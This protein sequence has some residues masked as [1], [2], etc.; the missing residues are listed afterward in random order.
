MNCETCRFFLARTAMDTGYCRRFPPV[1]MYAHDNPPNQRVINNFP[2]VLKTAWCGEYLVDVV[3]LNEIVGKKIRAPAMDKIE[4]QVR[5]GAASFDAH[6][7]TPHFK[8]RRKK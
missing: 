8:K 3:K 1:P 5:E 7:G 2:L 4:E 6:E